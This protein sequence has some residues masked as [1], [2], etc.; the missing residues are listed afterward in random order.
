[1][2]RK[3]NRLFQSYTREKRLKIGKFIWDRKEKKEIIKGDNFLKDNNIKSILFL[4]YDGKIGDT[5][6]N[7]IMFR[8]IK[9][10]YPDMKIGVVSRGGATDIIS[11]NKNVDK[12]YKY[13]KN[14]K[15]IKELAKEIEAEKYDLLIDFSEM[16]RVNEMMFI[17]LCHAKF[18]MGI[19]KSNWNMFDLNCILPKKNYHI[20]CVYDTVLKLLGIKNRDL[21]Y[22]LQFSEN[23]I[24][25]VEKVLKDIKDKKIIVFNPFAASKHRD[26]NEENIEEIIKI[27][28]KK[29]NRVVI[30]I[31]EEKRREKIEKFLEKYKGK[32]FFPKLNGIMESA[33]LIKKADFVITPDTSI[34]H[35]AATFKKPMIAIY[36]QDKIFDKGI[37]NSILWSPNYEEGIQIFSKD[38]VNKK[39]E[40]PNI[41]KFSLE[42]IDNI[43]NR[44]KNE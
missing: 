42:E 7:T 2:I 19:N 22:D 6:I 16:L 25:N 1:M 9:K 28:L 17:N 21:S 38:V 40:E 29:E 33:Y 15:R 32:V 8:E 20:S 44:G 27:L 26:I 11:N 41:N 30:I 31:G 34:V 18:N 4:R 37:P 23:E 3:L 35:I 24:K 39:G 10:Y 12:I 5:V 36:R 13:E 14:R 43:L